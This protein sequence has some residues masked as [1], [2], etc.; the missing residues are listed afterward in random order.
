[1]ISSRTRQ[2][3]EQRLDKLGISEEQFG[4]YR[5]MFCINRLIYKYLKMGHKGWVTCPYPWHDRSILLH[6]THE[7]VI[8]LF[9]ADRIDYLMLDVDNHDPTHTPPVEVQTKE[10]IRAFDSDPLVYTSSN[11]GGLRVCYFLDSWYPRET[12]HEFALSRLRTAGTKVSSGYIEILAKGAGDRLPFGKDSYLVDPLT[13]EELYWIGLPGQIDYAWDLYHGEK[14][15]VEDL[16]AGS[17]GRAVTGSDFNDTVADLI[18]NG[19]PTDMTTNQ[20][21]KKLNWEFMGRRGMSDVE[22]ARRLKSWIHEMHNGNSDRVNSGKIDDVYGQIDRLVKSFDPSKV[23]FVELKMCKQK[24]RLT[25]GDA[26]IIVTLFPDYRTQLAT[27][28]LLHYVKNAANLHDIIHCMELP[29]VVKEPITSNCNMTGSLQVWECAIPFKS[30]EHLDGFDK[31]YPQKTRK[32]LEEAG[33]IRLH[34]MENRARNRCRAYLIYF[35][36][37][38]E[39]EE[40]VSLNEALMMLKSREELTRDYGRYRSEK[41]VGG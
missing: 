9:P 27:F 20:A 10:V 41:I 29:T 40:V 8:G 15:C 26:R 2:S 16:D 31:T 37:D 34:R 33:L 12:V 28:S 21:L 19:L 22:A 35:T 4:Q 39:S 6:L 17:M 24:K 11:S 7:E 18:E 36:F 13:F 25:I 23:Q 3:K 14:L 32:L 38:D 30:F 5:Q 1:M